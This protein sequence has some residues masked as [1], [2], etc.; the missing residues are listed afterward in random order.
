MKSNFRRGR[1]GN[2]QDGY[3]V[4]HSAAKGGSKEVVEFLLQNGADVGR[5]DKVMGMNMMR[6]A[7]C[8]CYVDL[9]ILEWMEFGWLL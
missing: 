4:L 1:R 9:Q 8:S 3:T 2:T 7:N 5:T 6:V